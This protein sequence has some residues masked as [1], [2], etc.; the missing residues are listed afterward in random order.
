MLTKKGN[1]SDGFTLLHTIKSGKSQKKEYLTANKKV[2]VFSSV[3][4]VAENLYKCVIAE[5]EC[6]VVEMD[7]VASIFLKFCEC[8][9][10]LGEL[11]ILLQ[12]NTKTAA[13]VVVLKVNDKK[14]TQ[15][16][17]RIINRQ[18]VCL[19]D[20]LFLRAGDC[21]KGYPVHVVSY[22][23]L[24]NYCV[25]EI[26]DASHGYFVMNNSV[27]LCALP[28]DVEIQDVQEIKL[29]N[30][31]WIVRVVDGCFVN[32]GY[33]WFAL[34]DVLYVKDVQLLENDRVKKMKV[35]IGTRNDE[36]CWILD[37]V[38]APIDTPINYCGEWYW[39]TE[40]YDLRKVDREKI[41]KAETAM[42]KE[43]EGV[44]CKKPWYVPENEVCLSSGNQ[45]VAPT[46]PVHVEGNKI[47]DA[48][49]AFIRCNGRQQTFSIDKEPVAFTTIG[50]ELDIY[51][52]IQKKERILSCDYGSM[53]SNMEVKTID[54]VGNSTVSSKKC[55][56]MVGSLGDQLFTVYNKTVCYIYGGS[57]PRCFDC[58]PLKYVLRPF[59]NVW[60]AVDGDRFVAKS[61]IQKSAGIS[62][63]GDVILLAKDKIWLADFELGKLFSIEPDFIIESCNIPMLEELEYY[64]MFDVMQW[65][66]Q[67]SDILRYR[68]GSIGATDDDKVK[69]LGNMESFDRKGR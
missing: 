38:I 61:S 10:D 60:V 42:K 1:K 41:L 15:L 13:S 46:L 55:N 49:S 25:L 12:G 28:K 30:S 54:I 27:Y 48:R 33:T 35:V 53:S 69:G 9:N 56:F 17:P 26:S 23:V 52:N 8:K 34:S 31:K 19:N 5:K 58:S 11:F 66:A 39:L 59:N 14:F 40:F 36:K 4:R 67:Y 65:C 20:V 37:K 50:Y 68:T 62:I 29:Q 21:V 32:S 18:H 2:L 57:D 16:K 6:Y 45:L 43:S 44:L 22:R 24:D 47:I 64:A 3:D 63:H 7:E 51:N